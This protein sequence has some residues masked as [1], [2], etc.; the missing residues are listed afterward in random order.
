MAMAPRENSQHSEET[1]YE[2]LVKA[3][4]AASEEDQG[5]FLVAVGW[6]SDAL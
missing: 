1:P 5:R 6:R 4:N 2:K 3:F